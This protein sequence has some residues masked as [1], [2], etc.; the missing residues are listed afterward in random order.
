MPSQI[1]KF[2]RAY[3]SAMYSAIVESLRLNVLG[4]MRRLPQ[5]SLSVAE[6]VVNGAALESDNFGDK[7]NRHFQKPA[8]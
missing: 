5:N 7:R 4:N 8:I 6:M 1:G 3:F 2:W